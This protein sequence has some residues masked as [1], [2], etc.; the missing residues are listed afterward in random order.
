MGQSSQRYV[1]FI[2]NLMPLYQHEEVNNLWCARSLR[3]GTILLPQHDIDDSLDD[4]W[5]TVWWQGNPER[6]CEVDGTQLASIALVDYVQFHSAGK[7]PQH[8]TDLLE[9]L[10]QHFTFKTGG[11]LHLPYAEEELQA[12]GKVLE[13]VK[14]Y[15]PDLAWEGLKKSLGL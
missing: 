12:F 15:G 1:N 2:A 10:S 13:A 5:I 7:A 4:D 11:H 9:H 14:R 8:V 6:A 3:D